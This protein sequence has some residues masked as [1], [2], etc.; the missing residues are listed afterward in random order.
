M[1]SS[2]FE[3]PEVSPLTTIEAASDNV[4]SDEGEATE[5]TV[6]APAEVDVVLDPGDG[7]VPDVERPRQ[8][9]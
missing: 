1:S 4:N 3:A 5:M 2:D 9:G 8:V 7:E 6:L